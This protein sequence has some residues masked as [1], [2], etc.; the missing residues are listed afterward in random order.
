MITLILVAAYFWMAGVVSEWAHDIQGSKETVAGYARA[1]GI[2][3]TWPY[4]IFLCKSGR[5]H[6]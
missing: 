5:R 4:W 6:E 3:I 1:L 2:G